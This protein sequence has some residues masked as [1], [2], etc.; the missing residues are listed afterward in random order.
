MSTLYS[1]KKTIQQDMHRAD[2]VAALR[3]KG[4]SLRELSRQN[5]LSAGTLKAALDRPYRKAE[6]IIAAAIEMAPE[7]IWPERY[8]KRN[9]TPVLSLPSSLSTPVQSAHMAAAMG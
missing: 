2:I 1:P 3:K 5:G 7:E 8:A 4:W 9:F 6:S